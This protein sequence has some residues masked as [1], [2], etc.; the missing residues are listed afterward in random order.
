MLIM[1]RPVLLASLALLAQVEADEAAERGD[2]E[3]HVYLVRLSD[4]ALMG[5]EDP[6]AAWREMI[7]WMRGI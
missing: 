1:T 4:E 6:D 7:R 2:L 5:V 3:A